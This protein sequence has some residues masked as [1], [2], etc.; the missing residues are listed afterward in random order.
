[1]NPTNYQQQKVYMPPAT[2]GASLQQ[3]TLPPGTLAGAP[4]AF[5]AGLP[6]PP[7]IQQ[8]YVNPHLQQ[9]EQQQQAYVS[10]THELASQHSYAEYLKLKSE[11]LK[12][13]PSPSSAQ[14]QTLNEISSKLSSIPPS[15]LSQSAA[16]YNTSPKSTSEGLLSPLPPPPTPSSSSSSSSKNV[17]LP[18]LSPCIGSKLSSLLTSISPSHTLTLPAST[19]ILTLTDLFI[20]SLISDSLLLS[21]HRSSPQIDVSDLHIILKEKWGININNVGGV[22]NNM[23]YR[24][25]E[26]EGRRIFEKGGIWE[27]GKKRKRY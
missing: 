23:D 25:V 14:L 19:S 27:G 18:S 24:V 3:A 7:Q 17:H 9:Q 10:K 16:A 13:L 12:Y 1:M 21:L 11:Q 8:H 4:L 26:E 2:V 20:D 6:P 15:T 5:L 22:G